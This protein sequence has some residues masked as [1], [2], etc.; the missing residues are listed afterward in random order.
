MVGSGLIDLVL[1]LRMVLNKVCALI[2]RLET[3][4]FDGSQHWS[5]NWRTSPSNRIRCTQRELADV[6]K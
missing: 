1:P 2:G 6:S 4:M 3:V 5:R